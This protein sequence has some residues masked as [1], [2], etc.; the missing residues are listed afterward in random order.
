MPIK[1]HPGFQKGALTYARCSFSFESIADTL[2]LK[3]FEA[4]QHGKERHFF[5]NAFVSQ[6]PCFEAT[7]ENLLNYN[8]VFQDS[9]IY[10]YRRPDWDP[11]LTVPENINGMIAWTLREFVKNYAVEKI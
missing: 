9:N 8:P 3:Y 2:A 6:D 10:F 5:D 11:N 7:V 1:F 4:K